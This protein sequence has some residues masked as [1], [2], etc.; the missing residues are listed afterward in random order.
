MTMVSVL[1]I[2]RCDAMTIDMVQ[3]M[4]SPNK[5]RIREGW[6][7]MC[8][9]SCHSVLLENKELKTDLTHDRQLLFNQKNVSQYA[10]HIMNF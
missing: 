5:P 7:Y 8:S 10:A 3:I 2:W 9:E 4:I 1:T 6:R